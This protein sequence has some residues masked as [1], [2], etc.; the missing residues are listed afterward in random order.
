MTGSL[1]K[2]ELAGR[3]EWGCVGWGG[4]NPEA[5]QV[6]CWGTFSSVAIRRQAAVTT[7]GTLEA[8]ISG[9]CAGSAMACQGRPPGQE[10]PGLFGVRRV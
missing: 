3:A 6:L 8:D 5:P 4:R 2:D 9:S 1:W 10:T 7:Q